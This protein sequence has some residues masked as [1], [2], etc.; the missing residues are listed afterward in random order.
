M[1]SFSLNTLIVLILKV[2]IN[3]SYEAASDKVDGYVL[4]S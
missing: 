2:F 4:L 1:R 3:A